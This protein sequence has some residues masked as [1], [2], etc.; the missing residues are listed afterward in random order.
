MSDDRSAHNSPAVPLEIAQLSVSSCQIYGSPWVAQLVLCDVV[1]NA[2]AKT[3][4][5][6]GA[7]NA[8]PAQ[9]GGRG[10]QEGQSAEVP[11]LLVNMP[12]PLAKVVHEMLGR[13]LES[14][15]KEQGAIAVP[16]TVT[17]GLEK[18]KND[19]EKAER[20]KAEKAEKEKTK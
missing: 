9:P 4:G 12:W 1:P 10:G 15:E 19:K 14:Y 6:A 5:Q 17:A 8:P 20:E 7:D 18:Q 13:A 3:S 16:S 11:K 2:A